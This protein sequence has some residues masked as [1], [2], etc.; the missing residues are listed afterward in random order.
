MVEKIHKMF[1]IIDG[2]STNDRVNTCTLLFLVCTHCVSGVSSLLS[3]TILQLSTVVDG[4]KN[5]V[6]W[7]FWGALPSGPPTRALPLTRWRPPFL[8]LLFGNSLLLQNLLKAL[9]LDAVVLVI[10][11]DSWIYNYL[12]YQCLSPLKLQVPIPLMVRCTRYDI[13]W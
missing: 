7:S 9:T 10:W 4:Y 12:C 11:H 5:N 3:L 2:N 1:W 6:F 8:H 13:M